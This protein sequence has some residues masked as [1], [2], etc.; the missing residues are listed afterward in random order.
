MLKMHIAVLGGGP[1]GVEMA[2]AGVRS[3]K[4]NGDVFF[5][6]KYSISPGAGGE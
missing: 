4:G 3:V 2:V 1:I 6:I 5:L